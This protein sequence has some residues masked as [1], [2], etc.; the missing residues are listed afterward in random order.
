[1]GERAGSYIELPKPRLEIL[2]KSQ[3]NNSNPPSS[4]KRPPS[5]DLK[6]PATSRRTLVACVR[7]VRLFVYGVEVLLLQV[8]G[9]CMLTV[10]VCV[11]LDV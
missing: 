1:M 9:W 2:A 7:A 11:I 8:S 10:S 4:P 6:Q 3:S 5:W